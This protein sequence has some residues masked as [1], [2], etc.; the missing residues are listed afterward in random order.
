MTRP[1]IPAP[2]RQQ[3]PRNLVA[4]RRRRT[5]AVTPQALLD[6]P[7]LL[8]IRP[9][10]PTTL[11]DNR[12]NLN[13]RSELRDCHKVRVL[14]ELSRPRQTAPAG[15][16]HSGQRLW[17]LNSNIEVVAL[18]TFTKAYRRDHA[19]ARKILEENLLNIPVLSH[20]LEGNTDFDPIDHGLKSVFAEVEVRNE[21]RSSCHSCLSKRSRVGDECEGQRGRS[22][23]S[24]RK[25]GYGG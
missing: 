5:L 22:G 3:C 12:K 25:K 18:A 10:P 15:G 8:S 16:I 20:C 21:G 7:H 14:P 1:E 19:L 24:E 13:L 11:V 4:P 2:P 17:L 9:V 6:D 23:F